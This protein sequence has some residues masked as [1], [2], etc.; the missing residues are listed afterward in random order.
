MERTFTFITQNLIVPLYFKLETT[1][2]NIM[3]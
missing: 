3:K 2:F 1:N